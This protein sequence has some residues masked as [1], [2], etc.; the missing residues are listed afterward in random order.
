MDF[1]ILILLHG[2]VVNLKPP[3]PPPQKPIIHWCG[4]I[5]N[6]ALVYKD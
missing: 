5:L 4:G 1:D 6:V 2:I 3:P